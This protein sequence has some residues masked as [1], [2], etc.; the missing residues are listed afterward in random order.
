MT[1]LIL[2]FPSSTPTS[3]RSLSMTSLGARVYLWSLSLAHMCTSTNPGG[4]TG[5]ASGRARAQRRPVVS[6]PSWTCRSTR[7][8]RLLPWRTSRPNVVRRA[9]RSAGRTLRSGA[10]SSR[11]IKCAHF[12]LTSRILR[13]LFYL[14]LGSTRPFGRRWRQG[15]QMFYD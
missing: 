6:P 7:S 9:P 12:H 13:D 15:V 11:A 2:G 10:G 8:R 1:P 4:R 3:S 5:R 14:L